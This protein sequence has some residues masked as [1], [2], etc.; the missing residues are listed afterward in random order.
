[1]KDLNQRRWS[2]DR[3]DRLRCFGVDDNGGG[4]EEKESSNSKLKAVEE[5]DR[6]ATGE[7]LPSERP[8]VSSLHSKVLEILFCHELYLKGT[9]L[10]H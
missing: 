2:S 1:M 8:R 3:F 6:K 5:A 9:F 7:D 4:G 10:V